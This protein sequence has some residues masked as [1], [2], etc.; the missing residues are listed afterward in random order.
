VTNFA[1]NTLTTTAYTTDAGNRLRFDGTWTYSYDNEG[2]V[3]GKVRASGETWT[4]TYD[5]V[6][7]MTSANDST[8]SVTA[9]YIYDVFGNR[10]EK[11]A[12]INGVPAL[13]KPHRRRVSPKGTFCERELLPA[14]AA[15]G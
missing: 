5:N 12:T 10:I 6:N 1:N 15:S 14:S 8:A 9:T 4:F 2:N 13:R 11:D 3:T 7:H